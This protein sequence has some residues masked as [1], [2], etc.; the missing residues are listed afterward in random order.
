[1]LKYTAILISAVFL[2]G[3]CNKLS[4][5][6]TAVTLRQGD[7]RIEIENGKV[8]LI[9]SLDSSVVKQEYFSRYNDQWMLVASS[10]NSPERTS[11]N[12]IPLYKK[13]EDVAEEYRLMT[14]E[15]FRNV[16]V[17]E[18]SNEK[19]KL[20]LSGLINGNSIEQTV[21]LRKGLDYF[22]I[23]VEATLT[24]EPK[25]EYLLSSFVFVVPGKPDFTFVPTVKRAD[26][27][28]VGDRKFFAPAAIVEK[29]GFMLALV[30]D[31]NLTNSSIV[32]AKGARPQKHPRIFAVPFDTTKTS[33]PTALDLN[34]K[35]GVT[36]HPLMAYGLMDYWT[37]Q[38][39]YW[40]HDNNNGAQVRSCQIVN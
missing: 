32:F 18:N 28:V 39:V 1:M 34:L 37:E 22:H 24:K 3:S 21:E 14:N 40:R 12:A 17:I 36:N 38:H 7:T 26:D 5:Q 4:P 2:F 20:L 27:D 11:S 10:Y 6:E 16:K 33:L 31:L 8:Q 30:P 35:S 19:A 9:L 25:L 29:D 15:G 23:E 13:G